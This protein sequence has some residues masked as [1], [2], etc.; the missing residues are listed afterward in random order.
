MKNFIS[1]LENE[2][3]DNG[4]RI[5]TEDEMITNQKGLDAFKRL[6]FNLWW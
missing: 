2:V 6:F 4:T 5:F 1:L 3:R